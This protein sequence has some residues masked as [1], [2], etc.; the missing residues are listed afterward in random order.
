MN[1][2]IK[3]TTPLTLLRTD[4]S[5]KVAAIQGGYGL[6]RRLEAIGIR[7]GQKIRKISSQFM[8]GPVTI[9]VGHTCLALGH[10]LAGKI[11]VEIEK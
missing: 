10:G 2:D 7:V 6:T 1:A 11:L 8:R 5:G 3:K 9:R 4:Q